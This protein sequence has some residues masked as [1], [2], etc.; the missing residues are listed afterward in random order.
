MARRST[1]WTAVIG[2]LLATL[3]ALAPT[4]ALRAEASANGADFDPGMIITDA[5]FYDGGAMT[6]QQVQSFL[7][8]QVQY[9]RAGYTC[10]KDY[11]QDTT[12][13][14]AASGRCGA[15][16]GA[17]GEPAARIIAKVGAACGVSQKVLL[18]LLQ[19]E[20]SLVTD[21]WPSD[22]QYRSATGYACPDT[23]VCDSQYY[24]FYNQVYMAAWQFKAYAA[25]PTG[26]RHI[27]G[28]TV[29]VYYNP[30]SSCGSSPVAIQNQ[31]TAG[32]YNYTPYQPNAAALANLYGTGDGC[33]SYGNR[34]FWRIYTDWFGPTNGGTNL[35]RTIDNPSVYLISGGA[36]YSVTSLAM[37][38]AFSPL[39]TVAYVSQSYLDKFATQGVATRIIRAAS[40]EISFID[41]A[42]RRP[43]VT[44]AQVTDWGGACSPAGYTQLTDDQV[45]R[46]ASAGS[47]TASVKAQDGSNYWITAGTRRE[48]LDAPSSA[49][50][51]VPAGS[52][53]LSNA[54]IAYFPV[55][56]PVVRDSVY[57][58][59]RGSSSTFLL[60]NSGKYPMSV[61]VASQVGATA[62]AV[63]AL[64]AES[65]ALIATKAPSFNGLVRVAGST[66]TNVL[67][68]NG[69]WEWSGSGA[70]PTATSVAQNL[71]DSYSLAGKVVQRDMIKT[72][73]DPTVYL[74]TSDRIYPI[75]DWDALLAFAGGSTPVIRTLADSV[76]TALP[77]GQVALQ[78]GSLVRNQRDPM[79]YVV[80]GVTNRIALSS[81]DFATE[82]GLVT[83]MYTQDSWLRGYPQASREL[84]WGITCGSVDYVAA[85]G[86][87]HAVSAAL[88]PL[89]PFPYTS[90]DAFACGILKIGAPATKFI[91][92]PDG[93]IYLLDAGKKRH[94]SSWQRW[95]ELSRGQNWLNVVAGFAAEIPTGADA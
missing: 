38:A 36:K 82:A 16:Q 18:V 45:G 81:F 59:Q 10:L 52:S 94:I 91:R 27:A 62:R 30:N 3:T 49:A 60:A 9:C 2:L 70:T 46:F 89:Y 4:T 86:S 76:V 74:V 75:S 7:N 78:P 55:G 85:A 71:T 40:G 67:L 83:F 44:C 95:L 12:S 90:L 56:A 37:L 63:G 93:A 8:S 5:L 54:A 35:V 15:Y 33:S 68:S 41:G 48:I 51:G 39:G 88:K 23:A 43:F 77:K 87:V 92:T 19:K 1:A 22:R 66:R 25:N 50:A 34:N 58:T 21:D 79:V 64:Q 57:V 80:N 11:K 65:L 29:N 24:G 73:S 42:G 20:Q 47:V 61:N 26:F 32:L 13:R 17:A 84:N 6:E 72:A 14:A 31:A 53:T 69:R 28:Q